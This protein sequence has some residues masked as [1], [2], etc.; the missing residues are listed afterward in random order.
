MKGCGPFDK[1]EVE[2]H[3]RHNWTD[4]NQINNTETKERLENYNFTYFQDKTL[5]SKTHTQLFSRT[6]ETT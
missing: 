6:S 3:H 2:D 4:F 5:N 1:K